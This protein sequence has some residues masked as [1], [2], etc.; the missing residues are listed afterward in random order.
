MSRSFLC[1][2]NFITSKPLFI[3]SKL[4]EYKKPSSIVFTLDIKDDWSH[5]C[6]S[7]F[8]NP[9]KSALLNHIIGYMFDVWCLKLLCGGLKV[10]FAH[11]FYI[12]YKIIY[13]V[14]NILGSPIMTILMDY[15]ISL[16][17]KYTMCT[18]M[19]SN[20]VCT[21]K[22]WKMQKRMKHLKHL[23]TRIKI[24]RVMLSWCK[25]ML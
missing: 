8:I 21:L 22:R 5:S 1:F 14:S 23:D 10:R 12:L 11:F 15:D 19:D 9:S 18:I 6:P 24:I 13:H 16:E 25:Q 20:K 4:C 2:N 17:Q 3:I 7:L